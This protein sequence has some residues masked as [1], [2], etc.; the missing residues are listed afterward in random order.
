MI[1]LT[2]IERMRL[3][4][5]EW[6]KE[7]LKATGQY[8]AEIKLYANDRQG[9]LMDVSKLLAESKLNV[10]FVNTRT[11]KQAIATMDI[12]FIVHG[13]EEL[14]SV[15]QKIRNVAGVIDIERM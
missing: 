2:D 10:Q 7:V 8:L 15:I 5:A 14:A 6:G 9:L 12:G 13:K 1:H 11:N 4:D 3:I